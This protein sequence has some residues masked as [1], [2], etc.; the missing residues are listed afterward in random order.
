MH[1]FAGVKRNRY[2][3]LQPTGIGRLCNWTPDV[4]GPPADDYSSFGAYQRSLTLKCEE[5]SPGVITWR[6]DHDTPDTVYYHC[7]THRYLGWKINVLDSCEQGGGQA[8]NIEEIYANPDQPD[9]LQPAQSIRLE[10]KVKP[11]DL[12]L[13]QNERKIVNGIH[14]NLNTNNLENR[15]DKTSYEFTKM[16]ANGILAAEALE[17]S[18]K[19]RTKAHGDAIPLMKPNGDPVITSA[20]EPLPIFLTPPKNIIDRPF[21]FDNRSP[22]IRERNNSITYILPNRYKNHNKQNAQIPP[23]LPP[24][25]PS[26][27]VIHERQKVTK[28]SMPPLRRDYNA[29]AKPIPQFPLQNKPW[30][31]QKHLL[32]GPTP[33]M[34][35]NNNNKKF[36]G[37]IKITKK[38]FQMSSAKNFGF[39]PN[40][41]V[42]ESGFTP[43][44]ER[45]RTRERQRERETDISDADYES[46]HGSQYETDDYPEQK[47][48]RSDTGNTEQ[49]D[50]SA[51]LI[52]TFEPMFIPSPLDSTSVSGLKS[53]NKRFTGELQNMEIEND[54][55][56]M[57]M[58][59]GE[60]H[61]YYL[62]PDNENKKNDDQSTKLY[63]AGSVVT[64]D[65]RAVID[66]SLVES[67]P[68]FPTPK[69]SGNIMGDISSTEQLLNLP[70]FGPFRGEIPPLSPEQ[71]KP[72][73][74]QQERST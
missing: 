59:A 6:P 16:I 48:R 26:R 50:R 40:S 7:F 21:R 35:S 13:L 55:D 3:A 11:N 49:S 63:P 27:K 12:F 24:L 31:L 5:G 65:G 38:D 70:Q 9:P 74:A 28:I 34:I 36:S 15:N 69:R 8:S 61:A 71:M 41:V 53:P 17:D 72:H 51:L 19:N 57:A 20:V 42:V 23:P 60:L 64:Y 68:D 44:S 58:A 67:E 4:D 46:M 1:I 2:G 22:I 33:A 18:L 14:S 43:I 62:P 54:E 56:K 66:K 37:P 45:E 47:Q 52:K 73:E 10:T 25:P 30:S 32:R 39:Q 29:N